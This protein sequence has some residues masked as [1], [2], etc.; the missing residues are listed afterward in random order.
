MNQEPNIHLVDDDEV[1][2]DA[3]DS[4]F[5]S[6]RLALRTYVDAD[7]F[8]R[9]WQDDG[10][11]GTP[12]CLLLDVR[13]PGMSGLELFEQLKARGLA[14]H[15]AVIFLTGHGD[16]PMAVEALRGGAYYFF[17]K[18]HSGNQL[19]DRVVESLE[20]VHRVAES[21]ARG[22][23]A[24]LEMLSPRERAI[25]R[26]IADGQTNRQIADAL[27]ISVRT[28][29]VHRA[30]IFSKLEVKSAVGLVQLLAKAEG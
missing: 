15:H 25:A 13:M 9:A 12:A 27:Y 1:V 23:A 21:A 30:R 16:I 4:L 26:Q 17:E 18:P 29:E 19:V 14:P 22:P 7:A 24:A 2:R 20:H 28:V 3:L 11:A 5:R 6:R 10:L 8:L